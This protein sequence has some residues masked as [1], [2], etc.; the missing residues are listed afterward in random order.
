MVYAKRHNRKRAETAAL[1]VINN[2]VYTYTATI[3]C[4]FAG[5]TV[6]LTY[7]M[8]YKQVEIIITSYYCIII[9]YNAAVS[10]LNS[11]RI[12]IVRTGG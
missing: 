10:V 5:V 4:C 6:A 8:F 12:L 11:V 2:I 7:S 9:Q 3:I 1:L